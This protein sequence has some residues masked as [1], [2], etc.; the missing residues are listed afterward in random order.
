LH[1][2]PGRHIAGALASGAAVDVAVAEGT[3]TVGDAVET[4]AGVQLSCVPLF[5]AHALDGGSLPKLC[6]AASGFAREETDDE[7]ETEAR[8]HGHHRAHA[9]Q[10][11][12]H[13]G[14]LGDRERLQFFGATEVTQS[15]Q[16]AVQALPSMLPRRGDGAPEMREKIR[17]ECVGTSVA[18]LT[19]RR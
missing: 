17:V 16:V 7:D 6:S 12:R 10:P 11:M 4:S 13:R 15:R 14:R 5:S 1:F 3:G 18:L 9:V 2:I 19:H 8:F